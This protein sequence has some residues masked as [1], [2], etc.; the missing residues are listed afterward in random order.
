MTHNKTKKA[1]A[2]AIFILSLYVSF[3]RENLAEHLNERLDN[4]VYLSATLPSSTSFIFT[5]DSKVLYLSKWVM[6]GGFILIF[7]L[8][9]MLIGS[10]LFGNTKTLSLL[11]KVELLVIALSCSLMFL[12]SVTENTQTFYLIVRKLIWVIESPIIIVLTV[13]ALQIEQNQRG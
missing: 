5:I 9:A 2:I 3:L 13:L 11:W 8:L 10:I 4:T 6:T 7:F 1:L 12:G